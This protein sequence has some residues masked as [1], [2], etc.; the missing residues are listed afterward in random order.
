MGGLK[1]KYGSGWPVQFLRQSLAPS[2]RFDGQDFGFGLSFYSPYGFPKF[3]GWPALRL[4]MIREDGAFRGRFD[5]SY[6]ASIARLSDAYVA[7]GYDWGLER[8]RLDELGARTT[9]EDG[10]ALEGGVQVRYRAFGVR[11]GVRGTVAGGRIDPW[12]VVAELGYGPRPEHAK[13]H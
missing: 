13:V 11:A 5:L 8:T 2:L 6:T 1:Y 3:A 7:V 12:R 4:G 10:G 9:R